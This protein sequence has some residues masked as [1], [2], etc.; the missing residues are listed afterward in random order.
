MIQKH[1]DA[2]VMPVSLH[3]FLVGQPLSIKHMRRAFEHMLKYKDDVWFAYPGE[4][5]AHIASLPPGT[6]PGD[7][8]WTKTKAANGK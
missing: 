8:T 5:A 1:G 2:L 3:T 4:I 7:G 6:V